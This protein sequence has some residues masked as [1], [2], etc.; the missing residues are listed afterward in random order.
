[1]HSLQLP[2]MQLPGL[3]ERFTEQ[4]ILAVIRTMP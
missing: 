2:V 1:M 4:E 3:D